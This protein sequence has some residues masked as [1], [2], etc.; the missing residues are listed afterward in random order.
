MTGPGIVALP[1]LYHEAGWVIPSVLMCIVAAISSLA[2]TALCEA[3]RLVPGNRN[4]D[5]RIEVSLPLVVVC[6]R[7]ILEAAALCGPSTSSF[8]NN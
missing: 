1:L 4:F 6:L 7:A 8:C 3:M 2:S 5:K